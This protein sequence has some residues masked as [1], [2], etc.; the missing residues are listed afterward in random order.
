MTGTAPIA[1]PDLA[2]A[3]SCPRCGA[4]L[5]PVSE[6]RLSARE[7][8][9]IWSCTRRCSEWSVHVDM[10]PVTVE[11][12]DERAACGTEPGYSAHRRRSEEPCRPCRDAHADAKRMRRAR[13]L[14]RVGG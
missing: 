13:Q 3:M 5:A 1:G 9:S 6:R 14:E 4:D 11:R 10:V 8:S 7:H 2:L 12:Q